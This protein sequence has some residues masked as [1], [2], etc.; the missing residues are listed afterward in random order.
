VV[1]KRFVRVAFELA[2]TV[3]APVVGMSA[4]QVSA[5]IVTNGAQVTVCA[6]LVV[7]MSNN[8]DAGFLEDGK[9]LVYDVDNPMVHDA[10]GTFNIPEGFK[11]RVLNC[12]QQKL[13]TEG[14]KILSATGFG[15]QGNFN[16]DAVE[17]SKCKA[18]LRLKEDG[19]Y[20]YKVKGI[21]VKIY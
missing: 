9:T 16:R 19:L 2:I 3:A 5:G 6:P 11:V 1:Q 13:S 7:R 18:R 12:T 14:V 4:E 20:L 21:C 17:G 10:G 8:Q 15:N